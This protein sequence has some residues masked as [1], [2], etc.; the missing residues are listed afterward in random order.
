[1]KTSINTIIFDLGGVLIDWNPE[2]VYLDV[3][4]GDRKK[5]EWFFETVC[6]HDWNEN[7]DAGYPLKQAT[8]DR[9]AMFPEHEELIR[10]FYGCWEDMLGGAIEGTVSIL[11]KLIDHPNYKVVA[12]TNWSAET[13][14]IALERFEFLHWFEGILVSGAEQTR[15]P[16]PEIYELTLDRF[17]ITAENAL[18]IDD[19]L[20][21]IKAAEAMGINGIHFES[22]E[23]LETEL[24]KNDVLL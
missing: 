21:N 14:P 6:T 16:F 4:N 7:Q 23:Q 13:F 24:L 3:F 20:R 18:F 19:N 17:N 10:M 12:L 8:E 22:P 15:K 11:K 9:I 2:Y 1:M 5:M